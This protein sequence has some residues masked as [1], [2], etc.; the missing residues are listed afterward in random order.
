M[1]TAELVALCREL[2]T[3]LDERVHMAAIL[4]LDPHQQGSIDEESFVQW[5]VEQTS[6]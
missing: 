4:R 5:W 3:P 1:E 2:H 6:L